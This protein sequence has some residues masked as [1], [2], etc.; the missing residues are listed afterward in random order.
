MRIKLQLVSRKQRHCMLFT[1]CHREWPSR[2]KNNKK[3][4]VIEPFI[5]L[6]AGS[7]HFCK[8]RRIVYQGTQL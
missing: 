7:R 5:F 2:L 4:F 6:P 1:L 3:G 8:L